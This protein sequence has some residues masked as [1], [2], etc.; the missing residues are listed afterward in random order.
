MCGRFSQFHSWQEVHAY[1]NIFGAARNLPARYNIAP[2]Q[3]AAVV[4]HAPEGRALDFLRWGL[5]PSWAKDN[6]MAARMINARAETVAEK[7]SFR[8]AFRKRRCL[9]PADGFYEWRGPKGA[10]QPYRILSA[11]G[12]MFAFAG[13]WER[14]DRGGGEPLES[15]TIITTAANS[16]LTPVHARMPVI[17]DPVDFDLWLSPDLAANE[18]LTL[19][20]PAPDSAVDFHAVNKHVNNARN[21]DPGCIERLPDGDP[22]GDI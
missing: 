5:V 10:K 19:L 7:P 18:A 3:D 2:T 20:R 1:L 14:W 4:R 15:F 13:L 9:V 6:S 11:D 22:A 17:L 12:G 21:D 8:S 16:K